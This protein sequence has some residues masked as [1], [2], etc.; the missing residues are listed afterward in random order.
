MADN[1]DNSGIKRP[2]KLTL[3]ADQIV[4]TIPTQLE[5]ELNICNEK[6]DARLYKVKCTN[7]DLF[8]IRPP[9]GLLMGH[10]EVTIKVG[11]KCEFFFLAGFSFPRRDHLINFS[12]LFS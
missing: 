3:D 12:L 4:Y 11:L 6:D 10:S 7:N 8:K 2:L 9:V 5:A 1:N